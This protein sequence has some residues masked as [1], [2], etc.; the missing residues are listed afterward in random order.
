M[1]CCFLKVITFHEP[2]KPFI[3]IVI[4]VTVLVAAILLYEKSR[5][6]KTSSAGNLVSLEQM[7]CADV[8]D[9]VVIFV[10]LTFRKREQRP[11]QHTVSIN[12]TSAFLLLLFFLVFCIFLF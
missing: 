8:S 10:C 9:C 7:I 11:N 12:M 4:E 1:C 6:K 3:A 5:S 2:L